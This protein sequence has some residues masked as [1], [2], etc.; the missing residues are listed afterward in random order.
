VPKGVEEGEQLVFEHEG[1]EHPERK[2]G[3]LIFKITSAIH[4]IYTRK[5][6]DLQANV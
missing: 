5:G 6:A 2:A 3:H 4:P 1:D